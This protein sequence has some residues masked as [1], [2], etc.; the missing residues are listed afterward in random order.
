VI[1]EAVLVGDGAAAHVGDDFH[2]LVRVRGKAGLRGND[3]VVPH[4]QAAPVHARR[5][6]VLG[7]GKMVP[8]VQPAVP[9]TSQLSMG[10][11]VD[12]GYLRQ[13]GIR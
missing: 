10:S 6:M 2:V 5:V 4:P 7:E 9:G 1:A 11:Q 13:V 3:V 8:G 12:H